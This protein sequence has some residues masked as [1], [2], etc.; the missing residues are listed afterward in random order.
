MIDVQLQLNTDV[1]SLKVD[2]VVTLSESEIM[3][4]LQR[5]LAENSMKT[6]PA[7]APSR[8]LALRPGIRFRISFE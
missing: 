6:F 5:S 4:H 3:N 1:K 8:S 2:V 7:C